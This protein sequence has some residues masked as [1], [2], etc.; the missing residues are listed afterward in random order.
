MKSRTKQKIY[1]LKSFHFPS[2]SINFY[3]PWESIKKEKNFNRKADPYENLMTLSS[4]AF[5]TDEMTMINL[6]PTA[7]GCERSSQQ[8]LAS[9]SEIIA[10]QFR[11]FLWFQIENCNFKWCKSL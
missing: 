5:D 8:K 9:N 1:E 11:T 4:S 7:I 3:R 10:S 2:S 6:S